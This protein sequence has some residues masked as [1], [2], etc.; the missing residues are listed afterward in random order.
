MKNLAVLPL[1]ILY[2]ECFA[3]LRKMILYVLIIF[4]QEDFVHLETEF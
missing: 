1:V 2:L 4:I 3:W